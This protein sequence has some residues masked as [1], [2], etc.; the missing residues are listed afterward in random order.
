MTDVAQTVGFRQLHRLPK[1]VKLHRED[2]KSAKKSPS[3][4]AFSSR[5]SRLRGKNPQNE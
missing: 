2:A 4:F 5:P 1:P 3:F